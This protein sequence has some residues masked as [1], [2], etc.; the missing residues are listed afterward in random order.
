MRY[1]RKLENKTI[2]DLEKIVKED[3]HYKSRYRAQAI[4]LSYQGKNVNE[5]ADIFGCKIRTIYRWFDRFELKEVAGVYE[6]EGRGR[7]PLLTI[8][9]DAKKVKEYIKKIQC[10]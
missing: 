2:K 10:K 6:L 8:E 1:I 9:N 7:K 3:K 5:L 4:L